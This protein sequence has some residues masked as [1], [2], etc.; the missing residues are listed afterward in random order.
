VQFYGITFSYATWLAPNTDQGYAAGQAGF[1]YVSRTG[2]SEQEK[3][4]ANVRFSGAKSIRF[5]RNVFTHMGG[6]GLAFGHG[7]QDNTIIGNKFYDLSG[8]SIYLGDID[9]HHPS[10]SRAVV[11]DNLIK[12]NY[13]TKVG[14]EYFDQ[15]GIWVGYTDG[16]MVE[17]NELY[18][19]PYSGISV[20]W[21]WGCVDPGGHCN[22]TEGFTT[23][24]VARNNKVRYNLIHDYMKV[25]VDGGGV[26]TLG[27]QPDSEISYNYIH[28][29]E[30]LYAPVYLDEGT[31]YYT[32]ENNVLVSVPE[33]IRIWTDS[34]KNNVIQH[35]YT[36]NPSHTNN[37][38]DNV[39]SDNAVVED[40][41]WPEK[42]RHIMVN[43]GIEA[44]Y[45]DIK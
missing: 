14:A 8:G 28:H 4:L 29:Q 19:L 10:D 24:T 34:I 20:G 25:L 45:Q 9:D 37:G 39:V 22:W 7:G 3:P 31:Q 30:N 11:K 16:S 23:P 21:G 44:P 40:G 13:I 6:V 18:D 2:S 27:A 41:N 36:D 15:P 32:V 1:R 26:Y 38:T 5:E 33:W 17:H 12:N 35:N 43:A 42:A